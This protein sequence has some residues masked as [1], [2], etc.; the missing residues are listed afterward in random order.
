MNKH[1]C[2]HH[3]VCSVHHLKIH[4]FFTTGK[5]CIIKNRCNVDEHEWEI[6]FHAA[7]NSCA[8][9]E[10]V[11]LSEAGTCKVT[12]N[13]SG[14]LI[15]Q[16]GR[17]LPSAEKACPSR[18]FQH[19]SDS[20]EPVMIMSWAD[21]SMSNYLASGTCTL[22]VEC[23]ITVFKNINTIPLPSS[24]LHRHLGKLLQSEVGADVTF[25]VAGESLATHKNILAA[26]SPVFMAEFFGEMEERNSGCVEI[27]EM[28]AE[29][30]K[31]MLH[32]IYTDKVPGFDAMDEGAVLMAQHLIVAADRY[33]LD[34]LKL[35]CERR[36]A[37]GIQV[38]TA[39]RTLALAEQHGCLELKAKCVEFITGGSPEIFEAVLATEGYKDLQTSC[40]SV[41]T[42]LL[43]AAYGRIKN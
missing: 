25:L 40:P 29:V 30:F 10:L 19:H 20:S 43:R 1:T 9:L 13:L 33:A 3:A 17:H 5:G 42:E 8:A 31:A 21:I 24:K 32:F 28:Q 7:M 6:R 39:A 38:G 22:T 41:V 14:R 16:S 18:S 35:L 34:G 2:T 12:A 11:F 36:L 4:S 23:T 37:I 15:D 26:R 27:K